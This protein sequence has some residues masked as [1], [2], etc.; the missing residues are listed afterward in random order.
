LDRKSNA[1]LI[2]RISECIDE[3]VRLATNTNLLP[4][5]RALSAIER[6]QLV[7]VLETAL[8]MLKAPMVEKGLLTAL[9]DLSK[10]GGA[11]AIEK[12][13]ELALGYGLKKLAEL[14]VKLIANTF[15]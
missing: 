6:A 9:K 12:S 13:S 5:D 3:A 8:Q 14:L 4:E 15:S 7:T 2:A 11:K 10:K 1:E